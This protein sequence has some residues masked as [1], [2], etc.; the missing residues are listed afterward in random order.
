[1]TSDTVAACNSHVGIIQQKQKGKEVGPILWETTNRAESTKVCF[2]M[3]LQYHFGCIN[4]RKGNKKGKHIE[5]VSH[6]TSAT[7]T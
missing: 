4:K 5:K 6:V 1:M 3:N 2:L 7:A